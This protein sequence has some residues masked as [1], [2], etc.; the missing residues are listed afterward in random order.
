MGAAS[1]TELQERGRAMP[2]TGEPDS[3][4]PFAVYLYGEA[5]RTTSRQSLPAIRAGEY[6]ALGG[7]LTLLPCP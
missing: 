4:G 6:E 7:L 2:A 1:K 3:T 5:A